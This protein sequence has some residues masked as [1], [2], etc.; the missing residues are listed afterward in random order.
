MIPAKKR[1][2]RLAY[3]HFICASKSIVLQ[4]L[5]TEQISSNFAPRYSSRTRIICLHSSSDF[6]RSSTLLSTC[7]LNYY[8]L[9]NLSN[10]QVSSP[11]ELPAYSYPQANTLLGYMSAKC[12]KKRKI[13]QVY[14]Q[15]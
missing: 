3:T 10:N 7:L 5:Q 15:E 6:F 9:S 2:L 4:V 8:Q 12:F 14:L 11:L 1:R 13:K